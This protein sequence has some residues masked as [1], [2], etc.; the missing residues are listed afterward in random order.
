MNNRRPENRQAK[1]SIVIIIIIIIIIIMGGRVNKMFVQFIQDTFKGW[2]AWGGG[3]LNS[4]LTGDFNS[5]PASSCSVQYMRRVHNS[6]DE[7]HSC[8]WEEWIISLVPGAFPS[9]SH[10][11]PPNSQ[12]SSFGQ[13]ILLLK[14]S[15]AEGHAA[16]TP[17]CWT[18]LNEDDYSV[19]S[20]SGYNPFGIFVWLSSTKHQMR[21][22][23]KNLLFSI[24]SILL[25]A[26]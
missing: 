16:T 6:L 14:D 5:K 15:N 9:T 3:V 25:V 17:A 2:G 12:K 23:Q 22:A 26:K 10:Q 1:S 24:I 11:A 21:H 20:G 18:T 4:I 7:I 19:P 8:L 13:G